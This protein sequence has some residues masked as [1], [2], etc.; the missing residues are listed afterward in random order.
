MGLNAFSFPFVYCTWSC[1]GLFPLM[2]VRIWR[3]KHE[4]V[5]AAVSSDQIIFKLAQTDRKGNLRYYR[6]T[7]RAFSNC[8]Y[9]IR[10]D[11]RVTWT[12]ACEA[13][14]SI[15]NVCVILWLNGVITCVWPKRGRHEVVAYFASC[16]ARMVKW[17]PTASGESET[18]FAVCQWFLSKDKLLHL[19]PRC[20]RYLRWRLPAS[21]AAA[22]TYSTIVA[23]QMTVKNVDVNIKYIH[24]KTTRE[25]DDSESWNKTFKFLQLLLSLDLIDETVDVDREQLATGSQLFVFYIYI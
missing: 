2:K 14:S 7:E 11:C 8:L 9:L 3:G 16:S 4:D 22:Q 17:T 10:R 12:V 19:F 25:C 1:R 18:S 5:K 24:F 6:I 21:S 15:S 20:R 23:L 13:R